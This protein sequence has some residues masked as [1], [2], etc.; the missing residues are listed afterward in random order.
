[1]NQLTG[2]DGLA[3][4]WGETLGDPSICV[5]VLDGPV[6]RSHPGLASARLECRETL[7]DCRPSGGPATRHGTHVASIIFG[8]HGGPVA[9][10]APGCRGLILPIFPDGAGGAA[11]SCS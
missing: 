2:L 5:A 10:I 4:I 7:V 8:R 1:M 9:G 3:E 11:L 6:D